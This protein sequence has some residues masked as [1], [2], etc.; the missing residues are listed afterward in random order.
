MNRELT[1]TIINAAI[2]VHNELGP[3]LLESVYRKCLQ[4]ELKSRGLRVKSEVVIPVYY[5]VCGQTLV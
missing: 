4:M 5:R 3:G 1:S 2:A